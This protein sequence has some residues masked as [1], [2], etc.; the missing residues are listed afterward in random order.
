MT[1]FAFLVVAPA[2]SAY[3]TEPVSLGGGYIADEVPVLSNEQI[4]RAEVRLNRLSA[5][6]GVDLY[7]AIVDVFSSPS[8]AQKWADE[9]AA[10]NN[11][12]KKQY[13]LAIS[14]DDPVYYI[15][16]D[17]AGPI[18]DD[19]LDA[20]ERDI[21]PFLSDRDYAGAIDEAASRFADAA[22]AGNGNGGSSPNASGGGGNALTIVLAALAVA[23]IIAVIVVLVVRARR[24]RGATSAIAEEAKPAV[25]TAELRQQAASALIE[26]DD[27]IRTSEQELGFATAQFGDEA[28]GDFAEALKGAK[29]K[30][31]QA[32]A[33]QQQLDDDV[34]DTEEQ[35]REWS[36]KIV[37]LCEAADGDLD[38]KTAAFDELRKIE[39]EAPA[40]LSRASEARAAVAAVLSSSEAKLVELR[41]SYAAE[42]LDTVD[43]NVEQA[44]ARIAFADQQLTAAK[45]ALDAGDTGA[46]AV[47]I[48][49][50]EG[51]VAEATSLEDA[52]DALA[53][54]LPEEERQAR[55]LI[56]E[57]ERDVRTAQTLPDPE[58]RIAAVVQITNGE[59]ASAR[60]ELDGSQRRPPQTLEALRATDER[61][62]EVVQSVRD[63]AE[64]SQRVSR[65]IDSE[66]SH[67]RAQIDTAERFISPRRGVV[68]T[69]ARTRIAEA[70]AALSRV[71]ELR[72]SAPDE[73]L[74]Q[75][76]RATSLAG[77][78][79]SSAR[80]D[81]DG[82]SGGG[83]GGGWG[84]GSGGSS[85]GGDFMGALLG[86]IVGSMIS[87]GGSHSSRRSSGFGGGFGSGSR[88]SSS[89]SSRSGGFS[90]G[91][92][93]GRRGGGRY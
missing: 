37:E 15:S 27:A 19:Q 45:K 74:Q 85:G 71:E 65:Q 11:L 49:A 89:R 33:L 52:I 4:D 23:A 87:G 55:A 21:R 68:G 60:A 56:E 38:E 43:G 70:N 77:Q 83:S 24:R 79:T 22:G 48:H 69:Q 58:G 46:A 39:Q 34:P 66:I 5:D 16:A 67:A 36:A 2:P 14:V 28:T 44:Q 20:I 78:A 93:R 3:A 63:E 47:A 17:T 84:G 81:I 57:I 92:G 80:A 8:D 1:V 31:S 86:S 26:T 6:S 53:S 64:R 91:G 32:F 9:V 73:A 88:G 25:P 50:A 62:D 75:A 7:V 42:A 41:G 59:L 30:L 76:R 18:S 90:G 29:E 12:G 35:T 51:A 13:L 40:A 82:F 10:S 72:V 61:I 54:E